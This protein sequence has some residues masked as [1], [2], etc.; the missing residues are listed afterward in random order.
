MPSSTGHSSITEY[1]L[2]VGLPSLFFSW[3][4]GRG[5]VLQ[6]HFAESSFLTQLT[7][8]M[9]GDE[10]V[11]LVRERLHNAA[12]TKKAIRLSSLLYIVHQFT[13]NISHIRLAIGHY[14]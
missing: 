4:A 14:Y 10:F 1:S 6:I 3:R 5:V 7:N 8:K 2:L 9:F 12:I 11:R 13:D